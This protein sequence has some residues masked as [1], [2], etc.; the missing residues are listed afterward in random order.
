MDIKFLVQVVEQIN[1][2][3]GRKDFPILTDTTP[4]AKVVNYPKM[5]N[6]RCRLEAAELLLPDNNMNYVMRP[7]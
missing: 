4:A 7:R 1:E 2:L 6:F 5:T 3:R